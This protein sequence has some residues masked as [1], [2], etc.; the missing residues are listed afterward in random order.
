MTHS[1]E[2][3]SQNQELTAEQHHRVDRLLEPDG[4]IIMNELC[5]YWT[6]VAYWDQPGVALY[7]VAKTAASY[8]NSIRVAYEED[9]PEDMIPSPELVSYMLET[10][11]ADETVEKRPDVVRFL[12][13]PVDDPAIAMLESEA[14]IHGYRSVT[15]SM[16]T[17][18]D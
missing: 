1:Y 9:W 4:R 15:E 12:D 2:Q 6:M 8:V 5:A 7:A 18:G 17:W 3:E 11:L 10:W 16:H 13:S 14:A